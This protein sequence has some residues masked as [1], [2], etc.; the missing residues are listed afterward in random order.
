MGITIALG[1]NTPAL[2]DDCGGRFPLLH[3]TRFLELKIVRDAPVRL[4]TLQCRDSRSVSTLT[5]NHIEVKKTNLCVISTAVRVPRPS[6][7]VQIG[8]LLE[9]VL[10]RLSS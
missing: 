2:T 5:A 10:V 3:D 4:S 6:N 9:V 8:P 1:S 7:V